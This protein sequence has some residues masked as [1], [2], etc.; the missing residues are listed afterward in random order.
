VFHRFEE[1]DETPY[2]FVFAQFRTRGYGE[3]AEPEP[4]TLFLELR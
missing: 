1:N 4:P 2:V 3:V